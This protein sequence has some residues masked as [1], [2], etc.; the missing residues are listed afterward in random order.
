MAAA[1]INAFLYKVNF[2]SLN[3][4]FYLS[5]QITKA[6]QSIRLTRKRRSTTAY[7]AFLPVN[8]QKRWMFWNMPYPYGIADIKRKDMIDFDE[9]G[10]ELS[11]A[12]R[13]IGKTYIGDCCNQSGLYS[14]TDKL[15]LLLA[16]LGDEELTLR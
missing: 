1:E 12:E 14:K 2:G 9:C 6:E 10:I 8:L 15:N 3:F 4:R 16:I 7:Q 5:S 13:D 11:T